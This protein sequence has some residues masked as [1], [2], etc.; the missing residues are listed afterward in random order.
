MKAILKNWICF[1]IIKKKLRWKGPIMVDI[2]VVGS[3]AYDTVTT[4]AGKAERLLGGSANYFSVAAAL[5]AKTRVIGVVGQDYKDAD[6]KLLSDRGVD[7][8]GMVRVP[9]KTFHW[10][11][12]YKDDMNQAHTIETA[13]NVF[14]HFDPKLGDVHKKCQVL[15]LA[16]I[17]PG[18]Q[19]SVLE[20]VEKPMLVAMDTMNL[21]IDI[22][23]NALLKVIERVDLL[24]INETEAKMLTRENNLIHASQSIL[25]MGPKAVVIKRGEYGFIMA[26]R[27]GFFT[28]PAFPTE[29]VVDPTGAGDTFAGGVMGYLAR[30]GKPLS[31]P[32]LK[33][34]CVYGTCLASLTIQDFGLNRLKSVTAN[35]LETRF[36]EYLKIVS[37]A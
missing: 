19:L 34:A 36:H 8:S 10:E 16:N 2:L 21:W 17:A 33:K 22:Q 24:S 28:L 11:G 12:E 18:L 23:R 32:E 15:F 26:S 1:Q 35:E 14:E 29:N 25:K 6:M 3:L 5:F 4:P 30:V 31:I 20:Q 27:E 13:L 9:G 7:V 37:L